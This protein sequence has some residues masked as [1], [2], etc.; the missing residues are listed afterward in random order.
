MKWIV[1]PLIF[2]VLMTKSFVI[3]N[4]TVDDELK[5][6]YVV[7]DGVMGGLSKGNLT[8]TEEGH[9]L[10]SGTVSLEN[11]GGFS[12]LRHDFKSIN[13]EKYTRLKLRV[14]G[15]GKRYQIRIRDDRSQYYS[16]ITYIS[17]TTEWETITINL[18]TLFP[19]F[20]GTKLNKPNFDGKQISQF[21]ILI[22]NKKS[23]QFNLLIDS[24]ELE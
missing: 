20:R 1:S 18:N 10:F 22:G 13:S 23:E 3:Y 12:S 7:N 4:F 2:S 6:W 16:Y 14:K 19:Y 9:A 21:G 17:T 5:N 24:I 11:N 15:D 8:I